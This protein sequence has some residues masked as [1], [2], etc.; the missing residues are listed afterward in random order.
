MCLLPRALWACTEPDLAVSI[1]DAMHRACAKPITCKVRVLDNKADTL[2]LCRR[3]QHA[4]AQMIT[5]HGRT[6][7]GRLLAWEPQPGPAPLTPA[8]VVSRT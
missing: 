3:F 6:R 4:G 7:V 8:C 2:A 1:I 5:V